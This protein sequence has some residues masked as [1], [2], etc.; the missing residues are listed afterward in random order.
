METFNGD[1]SSVY[2]QDTFFSLSNLQPG[3]NYSISIS[4]VAQGIESVERSIYQATS[5][6]SRY[7]NSKLISF[8]FWL[9][10]SS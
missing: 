9:Q 5:K 10:I 4:A 3:R 6:L 2:V 1:S 8:L 7:K